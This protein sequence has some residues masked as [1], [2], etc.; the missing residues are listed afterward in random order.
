[1]VTCMINEAS[2]EVKD[3]VD[4]YHNCCNNLTKSVKSAEDKL[5][6][7]KECCHN[8]EADLATANINKNHLGRKSRN[9]TRS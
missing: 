1:M 3:S 4:Y 7:E 5:S 8:T 2:T 6:S 9:S